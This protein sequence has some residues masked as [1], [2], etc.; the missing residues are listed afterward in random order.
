MP[1]GTQGLRFQE[2][3]SQLLETQAARHPSLLMF[4]D[5]RTQLSVSQYL[6]RLQGPYP[7]L[8]LWALITSWSC[9]LL[10]GHTH[11]PAFQETV[12]SGP[13]NLAPP[14]GFTDW[15]S[16]IHAPYAEGSFPYSAS[17]GFLTP[18]LYPLSDPGRSGPFPLA[19]E[20]NYRVGTDA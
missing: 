20:V 10:S 5:W 13:G 11:F 6:R 16:S 14:S 2:S 17:E 19:M 12:D 7:W 15:D 1:S 4:R 3:R 18:D 9:L 8:C